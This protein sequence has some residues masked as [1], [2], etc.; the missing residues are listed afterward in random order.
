MN[1]LAVKNTTSECILGYV[2]SILAI[3]K[4]FLDYDKIIVNDGGCGYDKGCRHSR[5]GQS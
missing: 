5:V 1:V 2:K 3:G 4:S